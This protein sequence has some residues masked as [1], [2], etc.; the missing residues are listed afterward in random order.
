LAAPQLVVQEIYRVT[1]GP[2]SDLAD[3]GYGGHHC[4]G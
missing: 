3:P 2:A 1:A 4:L